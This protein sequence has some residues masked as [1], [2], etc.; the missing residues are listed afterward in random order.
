MD[1]S[2]YNTADVEGNQLKYCS[3]SVV[4]V[5]SPKGIY[6]G[7][8]NTTGANITNMA[9]FNDIIETMSLTRYHFKSSIYKAKLWAVNTFGR[10][11]KPY[12]KSAKNQ[13]PPLPRTA[14]PAQEA[15]RVDKKKAPEHHIGHH[16][17][18]LLMQL[19]SDGQVHQAN[20]LANDLG[21]EGK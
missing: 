20:S 15:A 7:G 19:C 1:K 4:L 12:T 17:I 11:R 21:I 18:R 5:K 16:T 3:P 6:F 2:H 13:T 14:K 8:K 9:G 10:M